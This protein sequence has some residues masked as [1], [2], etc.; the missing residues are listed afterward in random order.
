MSHSH[1]HKHAMGNVI[2]IFPATGIQWV[3][4]MSHTYI[5]RHTVGIV[6]LMFPATGT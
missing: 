5:H 3:D 6:I 2:L 1:F 4:V